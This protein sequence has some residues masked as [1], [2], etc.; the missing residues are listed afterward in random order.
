M[1]AW[2][3]VA[4]LLGGAQPSHAEESREA[5]DPA[6]DER[7][8]AVHPCDEDNPPEDG[9]APAEE[10]ATEEP[11]AEDARAEVAPATAPPPEAPP[12]EIPPDAPAD[13]APVASAAPAPAPARAPVEPAAQP[14]ED[15]APDPRVE[16]EDEPEAS[17]ASVPAEPEAEEREG[18][19]FGAVPTPN[20]NS[21]DGFGFG[22]LAS[23]YWYEKGVQPYRY[24]LTLLLFMTTNLV[25]DHQVR[26]DA[27]DLFDLP[28]RFTFRGGYYQSLT[29]NFCGYGNQVTCSVGVAE[30]A[31]DARGL[32]DTQ[33]DDFIRRY[34]KIRFVRPYAS[35]LFRWR[36]NDRPHKIELMGGWRGHGYI[37]GNPFSD[38]DY[39]GEFDLEWRPYPGSHYAQT[40]PEGEPGFASVFQ[41]GFMLDDRDIEA[42]PTEGY[43][44]EGSVRGAHLFTGSTWDY[45]GVNLTARGYLPLLRYGDDDELALVLAERFV[46]DATVGDLPVQ[47]MIRVGGSWDYTAFG[48]NPM[49]RG[50]RVQRY[51][52]RI[53][54]LSQTELRGDFLTHKLF[55]QEFKWTG[56]G[57]LDAGWVAVDWTDI[58]GDPLAVP[59][60]VG[61]GLRL[62]WEENFIIKLDLATSAAEGWN[63]LPPGIYIDIGHP[64]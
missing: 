42:A 50:I 53:K 55:G 7:P 49:G 51:I 4:L 12:A 19:G 32:T 39:D 57:F 41:V 34:Y 9:C 54:A 14:A 63:L 33:R 46:F 26:F 59:F 52:G 31:A 45:A 28:L 2:I 35:G 30:A 16:T 43:W 6:G 40:Y 61:A 15:P 8:A 18:L 17:A 1:R 44:V 62:A 5:E 3:I 22:A 64:F 37:P 58:G 29:Q 25:M 20:Y 48:G 27:V 11:P 38:D 21:D 13:P 23:L 60:G 47:E 36:F 10:A 56:V 24:A